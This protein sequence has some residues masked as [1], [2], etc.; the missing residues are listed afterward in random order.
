VTLTVPPSFTSAPPESELPLSSKTTWVRSSV[1]PTVTAASPP[2]ESEEK[3]CETTIGSAAVPV[4]VAT[5]SLVNAPPLSPL[6]LYE[7]T[8]PSATVIMPSLMMP[9]PLLAL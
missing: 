7:I 6:S 5:P 3:F 9:P 1:A 8:V 4:R 2:N